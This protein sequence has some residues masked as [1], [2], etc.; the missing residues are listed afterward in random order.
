VTNASKEEDSDG[1]G[2]AIATY[3]TRIDCGEPIDREAVL[4]EHPEHV[5]ALRNYF[6]DV[7]LIQRLA[8]DS[9]NVSPV[10][11]NVASGQFGEY[12]LLGE[13]GRGGMGIVYRAR[14]R[15]TGRNI[16]LKM[17]LH[18]SFLS[19]SD[20][21][22]FRNEASTAAA[23]RHPGIIPIYHVGEH[24]G[25]LF[26]TMPLIEGNN[27]AEH[28]TKGPLA[29]S[30]AARFLLAVAE[31]VA[32]AHSHGI[33]H[34]DLKPANVL[35]DENQVPCVADFGLARCS[36]AEQ[37]GITMTGDLLGTPN[38]MAPEQVNGHHA[39]VGPLSDVY[40]LGAILYAMLVGHPP[41]QSE[42]ISDTLHKICTAEPVRP[43]QIRH[44]V[45]RELETICLKCLEKLPAGRYQSAG[46][47]A[48]DLRRF[49]GGEPLLA[50]PISPIERGRRWFVRNPVVGALAIGIALALV[51][52]TGFSLHYARQAGEREQQALANLYAADMNLAQQHIRS[53]AVASAVRLLELHRAE[54]AI[55]ESQSW[56]W[57]NLWY[58]CHAELRRFEGPQGAVYA[59][60][61]SPDGQIV[62]AGGADHFV[63]MWET[64]TGKVKRKLSGHNKTIR[65]VAFA[66]DG[67]HLATVGDDGIG[68]VWDTGTGERIATLSGHTRPLTTIAFNADGRFLATAGT[69]EAKVNLWDATTFRLQQSLDL[70]PAESVAFAPDNTKLAIAGR[71][72]IVRVSQLDANGWWTVR[73]TIHA[74]DECVH[75]ITWSP[76][77]NQLATAS[78]DHAVKLWDTQT[79]RELA[80]IGPLKEAAYSVAVAPSG[81]RL[82]IAAR[83]EP[84]KVWDFGERQIVTELLG[85]TA[86]VTC[87]NYCPDG[88]R[89]VSASED[90]TVR[91]WDA[92]HAIDHDRLEGH[93][94]HVRA[95]AFNPSGSM[96]A[97]GGADDGTI[98]LWNS[99]SMLPF[100]VL[101]CT[102]SCIPTDLAFSPNGRYLAA[103]E[104]GGHLRIW[105]V[106]TGREAL[107]SASGG[108]SPMSVAWM[109]DGAG[110]AVQSV[111]GTI[112]IVEASSGRVLATWLSGRGQTGIGSIAFSNDGKLLVT[113]SG[114]QSVRV[115]QVS[116]QS[117]LHDLQGHTGAVVNAVFDSR[118]SLIA[119]AS[120]DHTIRLWDAATGRHLRTF[121]G[122][123]G[124]PCGLAFS[125]DGL[126][127][128]SSSRDQSVKLWDV[129][130]GLELQSLVGHTD[131]ARDIAFSP[132]GQ[133]LASAGYDGT[134]RIWHA[135]PPAADSTATR[136]AAALLKHLAARIS[137]REPLVAAINADRTIDE[138]VRDIAVRQSGELLFYW[139]AMLAGH[140]AAERGDWAAAADAFERVTT[141]APD[142]M[143]H[144]HWLAMSGLAAGRHETYWRA[145]DDVL[146]RCG[147]ET[148]DNDFFWTLRTWLVMPHNGKRLT[149]LRTRLD[150]LSRFPKSPAVHWLYNIRTGKALASAT[151]PA[152]LGQQPEDWYLLAMVWLKLNDKTQAASAYHAGLRQSRA[153][154][155]RWDVDVYRETVRREVEGLLAEV[156]V[157]PRAAPVRATTGEAWASDAQRDAEIATPAESAAPK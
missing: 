134:V 153:G 136:E 115:W 59:A 45:P 27:L 98:I 152:T 19:S 154:V 100:R 33:I 139:P 146:R 49:L 109:T 24:R 21:R 38:Y 141:L 5:D 140:R 135:P 1:L 18:E 145:C 88:W 50:Q 64:A 36:G 137:E 157:K 123:S 119:S 60:V 2:S 68:L 156:P 118:G 102:S 120:T 4:A 125:T 62:A 101:R 53:G 78:T 44:D 84:L 39:L 113:A 122:H 25:R 16:A 144:W 11:A 6:A 93:L 69:D 128:A 107:D 114:D 92:A 151:P 32:A 150:P 105:D 3:L 61:F 104:V 103:A 77:G 54:P 79:W 22:R 87:V 30:T 58:Q 51:A 108:D 23:L 42:S 95:V 149:T 8:G 90:G 47:L 41:F 142:D 127:L 43:R 112:Q 40:A 133:Q 131:W 35:L 48:D 132:D 56:E 110:L 14:E 31:A 81:R 117:L 70:G 76:D 91:L 52:G 83:N 99:K 147:P 111:D 34:R 13:I 46:Q 129:T 89:L 67:R 10:E 138:A 80:A 20:V 12:D 121:G 82:A 26:Y 17:L 55:S 71:D 73:A 7:D 116:T 97:S 37:L 143:M 28:I 57:R 94:G 85:H 66:P 15:S 86:L 75:D 96:L 9:W 74:H 148:G 72:G 29:S 124:T 130:T 65:D 155:T 126:R 106:K 63:W